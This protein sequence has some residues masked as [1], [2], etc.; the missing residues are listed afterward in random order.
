LV[1]ALAY[2][3]PI[4]PVGVGIFVFVYASLIYIAI[5]LWFLRFRNARFYDDH[6]DLSGRNLKRTISYSEIESV[7]KYRNWWRFEVKIRLKG[8]GRILRLSNQTNQRLKVDLYSWL[9]QKT[10]QNPVV[11]P[12]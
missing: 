8:E 10:S 1:T 3:W 12:L 2:G 7:V 4:G 11:Y 9:S 5:S 6:A